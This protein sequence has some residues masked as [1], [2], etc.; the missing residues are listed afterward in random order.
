MYYE[1]RIYGAFEITEP[2]ILDLL[3]TQAMHRL[4]GVLQHGITGLINITNRTNR[5]EHSV[6]VM[7]LVKQIGGEIQEQIAALLHDVSHTALSHVIDYVYPKHNTQSYHEEKKTWYMAQSDIPAVLAQHGYN[8]QDFLEEEAYPLLEQSPP[9]LCADRLD[10]FFRDAL[11]LN[12]LILEDIHFALDHLVGYKRHI[13]VDNI[14]AAQ[15]LAY[16]Y[17]AADD[18]SWSN[19]KEIGLYELAARAIRKGLTLKI[20]TEIDIWTTDEQLWNKLLACDN[21]ELQRLLSFVVPDTEFVWDETDPTFWVCPKIRTIDPDILTRAGLN[22]LSAI[23]TSF[24]EHCHS[25][26]DRKQGEW[27]I[28]VIGYSRSIDA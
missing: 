19:L 24:A 5:Y 10:Y 26:Q 23:D 12:L 4:K 2:V 27:P 13:V 11:D 3:N 25:Y 20:I 9:A 22:P 21:T 17:I 1:D 18:A 6:G 15:M 7:L 14:K 16:Q 8:W 28:R